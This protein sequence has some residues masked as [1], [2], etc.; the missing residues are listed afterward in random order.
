MSMRR[1]GWLLG[2]VWVL[3]L[4]GAVPGRSADGTWRVGTAR[5]AITPEQPLWMAG[6]AS[7]DKPASEKYTDLW[8]RACAIEDG[9]GE[10]A[11]LASVDLIGIDRGISQSIFATLK[12]RY[13]LERRQVALCFSHTHSGP[14]V[15]HAL[16]VI[17]FRQVGREQQAALE[18]YANELQRRITDCVGRALADRSPCTLM[19][20]SGVATFAVN[21][22]NNPEAK[23]PELMANG[24]LAGPVDHD[25]PVLAAQTQDGNWKAIWFG[26]ACHATTLNGYQWC[27]DYPGYA[28]ADLEK[29]YP[30]STALF[31]AG[32]GADQNPLPR[33][34][35]ELA[36]QYGHQ[37]AVAVDEVLLQAGQ[38]TPVTPQLR[39]AWQE[40]T[41]T[42]SAVPTADE[43]HQAAASEDRYV[44][45]RAEMYL[46]RLAAG[47]SV[48]AT[49]PYPVQLW[50]L[51]RAIQFVCL[52]GEVVVDYAIRLKSELRGKQ[53]WVAGYSNDVMA[54]IPSQRV[55]A[56]GGYEGKDAM[57]YYGLPSPWTADVEPLIITAVHAL[58]DSVHDK[59]VIQSGEAVGSGTGKNGE[60]R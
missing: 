4:V 38:L 52:G 50:E 54:Y 53:T 47:Q 3:V 44:R 14:A 43:L 11:V 40:V 29:K 32:C 37:L 42:L 13:G 24:Q 28:A 5:A 21:R 18:D 2:L 16:E 7:R 59:D 60:V 30:G 55:L 56:E 20:G 45:A 31:W 8:V 22:R 9:K 57:V 34:Q 1:S 51:G 58:V 36:Q 23:V 41:L 6:Y 17:H 48:P 49:V 15:G 12:Q 46:E 33:R 27:G 35:L 25:V 10:L 19:S 26:Y 39:T